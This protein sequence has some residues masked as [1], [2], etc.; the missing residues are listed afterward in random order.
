MCCVALWGEE[1]YKV[2]NAV[3]MAAGMSSRFAPLS[4]E[5]PK[6]LIEVRSEVLI[7]RQ[8]HQLQEA[9][10]REIYIVTG[11]MGEKLSYLKG[12]LGVELIQNDAFME[13]NN[14]SS[15]YAAR[16]VIHNTYICSADNYF[17]TNPFEAYVDESYYAG[18][19]ASGATKEWC[20]QTDADGYIN[21]VTVGGCNSWYMLGHTFWDERFSSDFLRFLDE[22]YEW[23]QTK[24]MFWEDI[25]IRHLDVLNMKLR[26]YP[27]DC[28]FEF[29]SLDELRLFDSSYIADTRSPLLKSIARQLGGTEAEITQIIPL[30][31]SGSMDGGIEFL[32]RDQRYSYRYENKILRR[33]ER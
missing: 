21:C 13:R 32:F 24:N 6:A 15:I 5:T 11:Y 2:D 10:I 16:D 19:L 28:I 17:L 25:F 22:E 30:K 14:H 4:L 23:P 3:I 20:M 26:K 7:E 33:S 29:D 9:G 18:L 12:K 31:S 8:I 27:H 1:M